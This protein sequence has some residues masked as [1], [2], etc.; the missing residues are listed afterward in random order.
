[1]RWLPFV[2]A[3]SAPVLWIAARVAPPPLSATLAQVHAALYTVLV[4]IKIIMAEHRHGNIMPVVARLLD[5]T[6]NIVVLTG[7][8]IAIA[9]AWRRSRAL[10]PGCQGPASVYVGLTVSLLAGCYAGLQAWSSA[11]RPRLIAA[12]EAQALD[13]PYCT[14]VEGLPVRTGNDLTGLGIQAR[15]EGGWTFSFHALLVIGYGKDRTYQRWSYR[16][17]HFEPV[18]DHARYGLNRDF[19]NRCEPVEHF[20]ARFK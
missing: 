2:L 4:I 18:N 15:N 3:A 19:T 1:L 13:Q 14:E 17:G 5:W 9:S 11:F 12:A 10:A 8:A 16:S 20:A 6:E 7:D